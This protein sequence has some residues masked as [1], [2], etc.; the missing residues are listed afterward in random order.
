VL[1]SYQISEKAQQ[2][3]IVGLEKAKEIARLA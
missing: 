2:K 3:S 1:D